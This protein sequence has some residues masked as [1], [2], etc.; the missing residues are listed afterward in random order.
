M[1]G[2]VE[3]LLLVERGEFEKK[4]VLMR[5]FETFIDWR[6]WRLLLEGEFDGR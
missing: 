1:G 4:S 6:N 5:L 3:E 2:V